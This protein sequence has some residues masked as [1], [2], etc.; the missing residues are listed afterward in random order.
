MKKKIHDAIIEH[1]NELYDKHGY[2]PASLGWLK[3]RQD[4]R[5]K[6]F[7]E[8]GELN[9]SKILDVGCGFGHLVNFLKKN[10]QNLISLL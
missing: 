5:F 9:N 6:I 8:I 1:Y 7:A 4:L 3:G 2:N 10:I